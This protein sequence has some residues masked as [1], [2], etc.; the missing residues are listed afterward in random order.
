MEIKEF[1]LE[2]IKEEDQAKF[3]EVLESGDDAALVKFIDD[4]SINLNQITLEESYGLKA[5]LIGQPVATT[6]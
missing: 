5:E 2:E 3:K 1:S 6:N 4:R